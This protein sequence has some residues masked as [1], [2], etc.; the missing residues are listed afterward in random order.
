MYTWK[1][2]GVIRMGIP[3]HSAIAIKERVEEYG[4]IAKINP[5]EDEKISIT[6]KDVTTSQPLSVNSDLNERI[7]EL[8][9][10]Q[11]QFLNELL[12]V[13]TKK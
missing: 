3:M 4:G 6:E 11:Q 1:I 10:K 9:P 8:N 5:K 2:P 7:A 13:I 12:K